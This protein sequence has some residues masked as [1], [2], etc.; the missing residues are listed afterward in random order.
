[1]RSFPDVAVPGHGRRPTW[2]DHPQ[3]LAVKLCAHLVEVGI[4]PKRDASF[5]VAL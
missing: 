3:K 2:N 5:E 1:M 4:I